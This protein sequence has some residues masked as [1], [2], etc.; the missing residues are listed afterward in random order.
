MRI[1]KSKILTSFTFTCIFIY[2]AIYRY[3]MIPVGDDYFWYGEKGTY[4]LQH[5]FFSTN[6]IYGGSVNGRYLAN[7]IEIIMMHRRPIAMFF[8]AFFW[9]LLIWA[10]WQLLKNHR[11]VLPLI[12]AMLFPMTMAAPFLNNILFWNNG[13]IVYVPPM[14]LLLAYLA[15]CRNWNDDKYKYSRTLALITFILGL[16]GGLFVENSTILQVILAVIV[17]VYFRGKT[18]IFHW[19]YLAGTIFSFLIMFSNRSYYIQNKSG[20]RRT[21]TDPVQ[22]WGIFTKYIHL[23]LTTYNWL[24]N[25]TIC[26]SIVILSIRHKLPTILKIFEIALSSI[27]LIYFIGA[28]IYLSHFETDPTEMY[29][30]L[31]EKFS[32]P[33]AIVG[34]AFLLFLGVSI[35][36]LFKNEPLMYVYYILAAMSVIPLLP[37]ES[38]VSCRPEFLTYVFLFMIAANFFIQAVS[39]IPQKVLIG[40]LVI[41]LVILAS[42]FQVKSY[43]NSIAND[44]RIKYVDFLNGTKQLKTQVPYPDYVAFKDSLIQQDPTYWENYLNHTKK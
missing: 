19:T 26:A 24:V 5:G 32:T 27:F 15:I 21:T 31:P 30:G 29:I 7:F 43:Q 28:Q 44:Q 40:L 11:T 4:L 18:R 39:A 34:L 2:F 1:N 20:Y 13:F 25:I 6:A 35:F 12:V 36:I 16:S 38:P 14:A 9:T 8:Y 22:I 3:Y 42:N 17:V 10:I 23:W 33:D 37:I 41:P